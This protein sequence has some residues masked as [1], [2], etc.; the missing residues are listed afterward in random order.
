[1]E[2]T[3]DLSNCTICSALGEYAYAFQK[4]GRELEATYL[5]SV[6]V[7]LELVKDLSSARLELPGLPVPLPSSRLRQIR[8]CPLCGTRYLFE[9]DYEFLAGGS[10]D[11]QKLTRLTSAQAEEFLR[12]GD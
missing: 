9:T 7:E 3:T 1:M 8:R 5:P 10:E 2:A 12:S 11:E 4:G 6:A